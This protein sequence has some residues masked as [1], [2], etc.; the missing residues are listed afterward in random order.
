MAAVSMMAYPPRDTLQSYPAQ[1]VSYPHTSATYPSR[2]PQVQQGVATVGLDP[3]A[4]LTPAASHPHQHRPP[5][6]QTESTGSRSSEDG[7]RPSLP[8]ISNLLGIADGER[9][10]QENDTAPASLAAP[11][12]P[13][14]S[15]PITFDQRPQQAYPSLDLS[16]SQ[17]TIIP[18]TPPL[19][20]DSVFEHTHTHS[21]STLSNG[22]SLSVQTYHA[23]SALNNMDADHQRVAQAH[24]LKRHSLPASQPNT[25]PYGQSPYAT[26]PYTTSPGNVSTGSYYSPP[27][28]SA[29]PAPHLYRQRPLP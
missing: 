6:Q 17:R 22:S 12:P 9:P 20:N 5:L 25:S 16:S 21:P 7:S 19:R 11:P 23:G 2:A 28:P 18:P 10:G 8:S 3:Y 13:G 29:Y 1:Y 14:R 26:S 15:Q 4:G 27:D 24:F